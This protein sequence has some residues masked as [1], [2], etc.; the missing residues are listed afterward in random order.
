MVRSP[1]IY[2]IYYQMYPRI[3]HIA[4]NTTYLDLSWLGDDHP[5]PVLREKFLSGNH[6]LIM[7]EIPALKENYEAIAGDWEPGAISYIAVKNKTS[8]L[9]LRGVSDLISET[10]GEAYEDSGIIEDNAYSILQSMISTL[11]ACLTKCRIPS[12]RKLHLQD[13]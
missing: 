11:P 6:D 2:N 10:A 9:F 3:D 5:M 12:A 7:E 4:H 1:I 13:Q 8:L